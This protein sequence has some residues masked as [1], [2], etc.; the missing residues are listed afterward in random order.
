MGQQ[1][2]I[3]ESQRS[4][5]TSRAFPADATRCYIR[6]VET[7]SQRQLRNDNAEILRGVERGETYTVTRRGVPIARLGPLAVDSDLRCV[8]PARRR[9]AFGSLTRVRSRRA[10]ADVLD[11]LRAER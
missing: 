9:V 2:S 11:D 6:V 1:C 5:R 7:I 4:S 8:R 3:N 10:T